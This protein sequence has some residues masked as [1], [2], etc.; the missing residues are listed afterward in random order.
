[1]AWISNFFATATINYTFNYVESR[2]T[3]LKLD[4]QCKTT[5]IYVDN[6]CSTNFLLFFSIFIVA[7]TR[8]DENWEL[9]CTLKVS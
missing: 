1:M 9:T 5:K 8:A 4:L 6:A 2:Y 3:W 7:I